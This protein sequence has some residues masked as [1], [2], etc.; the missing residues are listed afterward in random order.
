MA[1]R[2]DWLPNLRAEVAEACLQIWS[3]SPSSPARNGLAVN[4]LTSPEE[5]S[6]NVKRIV[7]K[8]QIGSP[9]LL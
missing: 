3:S 7:G 4:G 5:A 8:Q 9:A 2:D 1:S 6:L